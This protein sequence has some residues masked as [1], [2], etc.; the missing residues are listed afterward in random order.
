MVWYFPIIPRLKRLFASSKEAELLHWHARRKD[1]ENR[2]ARKN[3]GMYRH[4]AYS[5]QSKNFDQRYGDFAREERDICLALSTDGMN[6]FADISVAHNTWPIVLCVYNLPP[7]LGH[8]RNYLMLLVLISGKKQPDVRIDVYLRPLID[9]LKTLWFNGV[10]VWDES[11][12]NYFDLHAMLFCMI[13]DL[14]ALY[15]VLGQTKAGGKGF[16]QCLY[17]TES[18]W[19]RNSKKLVYMR[20]RRFLS[21]K[22]PYRTMTAQFDGTREKGQAPRNFSGEQIHEDQKRIVSLSVLGKRKRSKNG[23]HDLWKKESIF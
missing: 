14:P 21:R 17:D 22:H 6:P 7:W 12:R 11:K 23:E 5:I 16:P 15:S 2:Q 1:G 10:E 18:L 3:D 9:D 20:T 8:K 4:P 19:L 13:Q